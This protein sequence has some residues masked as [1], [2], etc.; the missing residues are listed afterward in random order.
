MYDRAAEFPHALKR[1]GQVNHSEVRKGASVPGTRPSLMNPEMEPV[2]VNL[3]PR[4]GSGTARR[5]FDVEHAAPEAASTIRIVGGEL[6]QRGRHGP[7]YP[8]SGWGCDAI[9]DLG[10]LRTKVKTMAV[11]LRRRKRRG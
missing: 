7:E 9:D 1:L 4:A 6:D 10:R 11:D 2:I 3:P 8:R 5:E